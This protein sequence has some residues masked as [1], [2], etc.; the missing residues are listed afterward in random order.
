MK[1]EYINPFINAVI[2]VLKTMG[3]VSPVPGKP[4]LKDGNT[5]LGDVSG[6][7]GLAGEGVRGFFVVSFTES[8]ILSFMEK[9]L[10]ETFDRIDAEVKDAVGEVTNMISG[11]AKGELSQKG[12]FFDVAI[13]SVVSGA[14]HKIEQSTGMPVIV[15]PFSTEAGAFFIEAALYT[16]EP[17]E[18][19]TAEIPEGMLSIAQF[20]RKTGIRTAT[21]RGWL[22]TGFIKGEKVSAKVWHIPEEE[23]K[24]V[25]NPT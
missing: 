3:G 2:H 9:M 6:V 23:M 12:F 4:R 8:C 20:S 1:V 24:K 7:I 17:V 10:G 13:P 22:N 15:V 18:Q 19:E 5:A 25:V 21:I 16:G 14:R 11:G